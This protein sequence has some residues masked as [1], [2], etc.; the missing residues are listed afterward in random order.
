MNTH[1]QL[2]SGIDS[3]KTYTLKFHFF[4][5][6]QAIWKDGIDTPLT[7]HLM[8][9]NHPFPPVHSGDWIELDLVGEQTSYPAVLRVRDVVHHLRRKNGAPEENH[10]N[11][12][13]QEYG[14]YTEYWHTDVFV[15]AAE[16]PPELERCFQPGWTTEV[17]TFHAR[18]Q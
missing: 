14:P 3:V 15:E 12:H 5:N 6:N 13:H 11:A 4:R 17:R 1:T 2:P 16:H 18:S 9:S 8:E 7:P 10:R